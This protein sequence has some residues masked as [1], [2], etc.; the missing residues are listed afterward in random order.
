MPGALY[1]LQGLGADPPGV[2]F[3]GIRYLRGS[4]QATARFR[5]GPGRGVRRTALHQELTDVVAARGIPVVEADV[6]EIQQD[7]TAIRAAGFAARYLL[8][9]DGLHSTIRDLAGLSADP[10]P[11]PG[12]RW[13][14]ALA[15]KYTLPCRTPPATTIG[16]ASSEVSPFCP[17]MA[18]AVMR[19]PESGVTA[20][21]AKKV[22]VP[23][24]PVLALT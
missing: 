13:L 18:V 4:T 21:S 17:T 1:A 16:T 19:S 12:S 14:L 3:N 15:S 9:A 5:A 7:R 8:A 6:D 23:W 11:S 2:P 22:P 24:T 20:R 10:A